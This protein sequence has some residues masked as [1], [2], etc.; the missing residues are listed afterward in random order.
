MKWFTRLPSHTFTSSISVQ[1]SFVH[2]ALLE[3]FC[4]LH[5]SWELEQFTEPPQEFPEPWVPCVC[6]VLPSYDMSSLLWSTS[7]FDWHGISCHY[8]FSFQT[9]CVLHQNMDILLWHSESC[10]RILRNVCL[11]LLLNTNDSGFYTEVIWRHGCN[12]SG[13]FSNTLYPVLYIII[14]YLILCHICHKY[15]SKYSTRCSDVSRLAQAVGSGI[16]TSF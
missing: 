1:G 11:F 10:Y 12:G 4:Y 8:G 3:Q 14:F 6:F 2:A 13:T 5:I 7:H 15:D 16:C 9:H